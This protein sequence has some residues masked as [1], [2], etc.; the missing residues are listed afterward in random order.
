LIGL[1]M[2]CCLDSN[3]ETLPRL[4]PHTTTAPAS[5]TD[6]F[7]PISYR[8]SLKEVLFQKRKRKV[9][10]YAGVLFYN[11]HMHIVCFFICLFLYLLVTF[12]YIV[13]PYCHSKF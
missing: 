8:I 13:I 3:Q 6:S 2:S 1:S 9:D 4:Y 10:I 11:V 12:S 5:M 7:S